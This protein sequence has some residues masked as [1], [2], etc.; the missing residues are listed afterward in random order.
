MERA[1][2]DDEMEEKMSR[3]PEGEPETSLRHRASFHAAQM[4]MWSDRPS[5]TT[6]VTEDKFLGALAGPELDQ[7]G[8]NRQCLVKDEKWPFLL[9]FKVVIFGA[10]IGIAGQ[11]GLWKTLS[12][13]KSTK[14]Y[15]FP[16][17]I[18]ETLWIVGIVTLLF[19]TICYC[20]KLRFWPGAVYREFFHPVRVNFFAAPFVAALLLLL[21]TPEKWILGSREDSNFTSNLTANKT[22]VGFAESNSLSLNHTYMKVLFF[23]VMTPLFMLELYLYGS[24]MHSQK[25]SLRSGNP[26]YQIAVIGNFIG[27][28]LAARVGLDE[29]G[30][31][32][33]SVGSLFYLLVFISIYQAISRETSHH[34]HEAEPAVSHTASS[35]HAP[36][37]KFRSLERF[38]HPVLF[39]FVAPPAAASLAWSQVGSD[40]KMNYLAKSLHFIS[41]FIFLSL[42]RHL[43]LFVKDTPFSLSYW[44]Y[45]FPMAALGTS[46]LEYATSVDSEV[47][48]YLGMVLASLAM[49]MILIVAALTVC[50]I[51]CGDGVLPNDYVIGVCVEQKK[52]G[53]KVISQALSPF[54]VE[55][56]L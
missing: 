12:H 19:S 1:G 14:P 39:L 6:G 26:T 27:A 36:H 56:S 54:S 22:F 52:D 28:N 8:I 2:S 45:T 21:A 40:G 24:W 47:A 15:G 10:S 51:L 31:L 55:T 9:R 50:K 5:L 48:L 3:L 53:K 44:A 18:N 32:L 16:T 35:S 20:L 34:S 17:F 38:L 11:A 29:I 42:I 30:L 7:M 25:R 13:E 37:N 46:S 4:Q 23:V 41:F 33:F 43:I 49:L